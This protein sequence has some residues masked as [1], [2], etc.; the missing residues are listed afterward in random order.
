MRIVLIV[1]QSLDGFITCHE[2]PG[3]AWASAADQKW[4][5]A[6]LSEFDAQVMA[7][8]TFE[9]VRDQILPAKPTDP[10]R[11]IMTRTPDRYTEDSASGQLEFTADLPGAIHHKL[12]DAGHKNCALLGGSVA[13][14]AFLTAGLVNEIWVTIEPRI[15]GQGTPV[16]RMKQDQRLELMDH[17]R[18]PESDSIVARYRVLP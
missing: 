12:V 6:T 18:L 17:Q 9:T 11:I 1:A 2:V 15:F 13:H 5:R 8:A 10:T 16:V 4:F 7:R 3:V 14:D